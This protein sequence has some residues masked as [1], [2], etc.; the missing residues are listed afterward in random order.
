MS[1]S[2]VGGVRPRNHIIKRPRLTRLLDE[3]SARII[4][5]VAP[6]GYG[7]TTLAR[8]WCSSPG[9]KSGWYQCTPASSDVAAFTVGLTKTIRSV[10]LAAGKY[11]DKRARV[12]TTPSTDAKALAELLTEDLVDWPDNSWLVLDDFHLVQNSPS[13]QQFLEH[14]V[15]QS[16]IP[17]LV[18]ARERPSWVSARAILYGESLELGIEI[19]TITDDE[20]SAV[21]SHRPDLKLPPLTDVAHGC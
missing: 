1:E 5:L 14:L 13:I 10:V 16:R 11:V 4:L 18:T 3:T 2:P 20:A 9:R 17:L 6:A 15:H 19:L 21:L 8:E 7:K 12:T